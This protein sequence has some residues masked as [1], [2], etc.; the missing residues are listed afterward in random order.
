MATY[1][2]TFKEN[3]SLFVPSEA[4]AA[5][6]GEWTDLDAST[7]KHIVTEYTID[8]EYSDY[9]ER[10]LDGSEGVAVWDKKT[11]SLKLKAL[12]QAALKRGLAPRDAMDAAQ[13]NTLKDYS[14]NDLRDAADAA[15]DAIAVAA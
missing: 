7:E 3:G 12:I 5:I 2:V 14:R 15:I 10:L 4:Q 1:R 13:A 6:L 9:F 11:V 8:D